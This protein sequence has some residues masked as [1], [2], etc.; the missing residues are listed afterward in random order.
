MKKNVK[1]KTKESIDRRSD[2]IVLYMALVFFA[3][4]G[5]LAFIVG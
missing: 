3:A 4:L 2:A 1:V 5:S